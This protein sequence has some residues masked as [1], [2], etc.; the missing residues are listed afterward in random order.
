MERNDNIEIIS[1]APIETEEETVVKQ[2]LWCRIRALFEQGL[3]KSAIARELEID[4]KTVRKWLRQTWEPQT[5]ERKWGLKAFFARVLRKSATTRRFSTES[6]NRRD[7]KV[8]IR[9]WSNTS[10]PGG[11]RLAGKTWRRRAS[12][13]NLA[14]RRKSIGDLRKSGS[15]VVGS[16]FICLSW[17]WVIVGEFSSRAIS[18]SE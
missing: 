2:N 7:T 4:L 11:L 15:I 1:S 13:L 12:R 17:C 18:M 3:S 9:R 5:R 10:V 6:W 16:R 8:H 14:N